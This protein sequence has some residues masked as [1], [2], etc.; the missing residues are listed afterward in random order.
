MSY[1][2]CR[3]DLK[4]WWEKDNLMTFEGGSEHYTRGKG[5]KG[6]RERQRCTR[7]TCV[8]FFVSPQAAL[9]VKFTWQLQMKT[10]PRGPQSLL[11][12]EEVSLCVK[13]GILLS[14][15]LTSQGSCEDQRR[16]WL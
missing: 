2:L 7:P 12:L 14:L 10:L 5:E 15:L 9:R 13:M 16:E 1:S 4:R 3:V 11:K 8:L 6:I